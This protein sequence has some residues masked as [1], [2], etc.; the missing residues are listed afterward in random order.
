MTCV[1]SM[2]A[3]VGVS[4]AKPVWLS[5]HL[6]PNHVPRVARVFASAMRLVFVPGGEDLS[7]SEVTQSHL[8]PSR[9]RTSQGNPQIGCTLTNKNVGPLHCLTTF[10]TNSEPLEQQKLCHK[11][12]LLWRSKISCI[13][14]YNI[15]IYFR[16]I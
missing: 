6:V 1:P 10:H 16:Y 7:E 12:G 8:L 5:Q 11:L 15:Y 9:F 4:R 13:Y 3:D 2:Q 14:N